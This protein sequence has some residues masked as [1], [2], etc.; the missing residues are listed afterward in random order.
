MFKLCTLQH[1][2][3]KIVILENFDIE[4]FN[5]LHILFDVNCAITCLTCGCSVEDALWW[6]RNPWRLSS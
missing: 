5:T 1:D 2:I 4:V 6:G 3:R